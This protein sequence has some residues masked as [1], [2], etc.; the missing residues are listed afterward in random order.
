[1]E[2]FGLSQKILKAICD[3]FAANRKIHRV[4]IFGSRALGKHR[5]GSDID[6]ALEGNGLTL[7]D[8]L[9]IRLRLDDLMLP[10]RF[11]VVNLADLSQTDPLRDHIKNSG[12]VIFQRKTNVH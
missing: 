11:D 3:V 4:A 10:Y 9:T 7:D 5:L 6:L 12:K 2:V 1:M 8:I